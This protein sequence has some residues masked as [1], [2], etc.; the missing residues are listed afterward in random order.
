MQVA[1]RDLILPAVQSFGRRSRGVC[2][3]GDPSSEGRQDDNKALFG[4]S[5]LRAPSIKTLLFP[6]TS[7]HPPALRRAGRKDCKY[8]GNFRTLKKLIGIYRAP[9]NFQNLL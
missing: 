7:F 3:K 1:V 4:G 8:K 2:A 5:L 9:T 6:K